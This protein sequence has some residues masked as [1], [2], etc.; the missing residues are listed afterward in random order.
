M[1]EGHNRNW[2]SMGQLNIDMS[3]TCQ[4]KKVPSRKSKR[5]WFWAVGRIKKELF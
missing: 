2:T 1:I 3:A 4:M 5:V